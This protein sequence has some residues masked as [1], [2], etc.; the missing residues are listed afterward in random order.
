MKHNFEHYVSR[1]LG[2]IWYATCVAGS[3]ALLAW[4]LKMLV[5]AIGVI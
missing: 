5:K 3:L 4:V 2:Y 1:F